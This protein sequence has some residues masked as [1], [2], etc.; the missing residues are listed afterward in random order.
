[1]K[2]AMLFLPLLLFIAGCSS[3]YSEG[4]TKAS[5]AFKLMTAKEKQIYDLVYDNWGHEKLK[6]LREGIRNS[7][8]EKP[9]EESV[10][11]EYLG[12][13]IK[14][15]ETVQMISKDTWSSVQ[16]KRYNL[17]RFSVID[18]RWY[19]SITDNVKVAV[20]PKT[21]GASL[22]AS[23]SKAKSQLLNK[24]LEIDVRDLIAIEEYEELRHEMRGCPEAIDILQSIVNSGRPLT[25]AD[26]DVITRM[27]LYC[28]AR[29]LIEYLKE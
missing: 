25:I 11:F 20:R 22:T 19:R 15:I 23:F 1:M 9:V 24:Q 2:K 26:R 13:I 27:I 28:K 10:P 4:L 7:R 14:T 5:Q 6:H 18:P 3:E 12:D 29:V 8:E 21:L 17:S 16:L